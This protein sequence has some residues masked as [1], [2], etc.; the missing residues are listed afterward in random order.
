MP[1]D[2]AGRGRSGSARKSSTR[3]KRK[4]SRSRTSQAQRVFF[5]G[6]SFTIGAVVGAAIIIVTAY[7]PQLLFTEDAAESK[8]APQ[9]SEAPEVRFEFPDLLRD[10]EVQPDPEPYAVPPSTTQAERTYTIQA[11]SFRTIEDADRL[12]A[13]LLLQNLPATTQPRQVSGST[14]YRVVVGPF[15]KQVEA[16]RAM[17][18]LR[19]QGLTAI[20]LNDHN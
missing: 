18:Q 10:T 1:K 13:D 14:W 12:R 11:A 9:T 2:Y 4:P 5:H 3:R 7:A 8:A 15:A 16:N 17:T 20:W 6:P 19:S